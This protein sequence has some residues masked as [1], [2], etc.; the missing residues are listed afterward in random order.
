[1]PVDKAGN[2]HLHPGAAKMHENAP[3]APPIGKISE[4]PGGAKPG[5]GHVELHHGPPPDGSMPNAKFHTIHHGASS[6]GGGGGGAMGMSHEGAHEGGEHGK[7]EVKGHETM[8][9][10]HH[11]INDHMGEDGCTDGSCAEHGGSDPEGG[12]A[13]VSSGGETDDEY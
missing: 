3:K 1:M 11:A 2:F 12:A 9:A 5:G 7:G 6:S 4:K 10:A 13:A 8:H